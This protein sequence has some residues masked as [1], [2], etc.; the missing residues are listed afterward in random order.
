RGLRRVGG[1][2][3]KGAS[4]CGLTAGVFG[5]AAKQPGGVSGWLWDS[6][7]IAGKGHRVWLSLTAGLGAFGVVTT[8][9]VFVRWF[10]SSE[11]G[12]LRSDN[13]TKGCVSS[14][15]APRV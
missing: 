4:G 2:N 6:R 11:K 13:N 3:H 10:S 1:I 5:L 14:G 8:P 9:R 15:F 12:V 7:V